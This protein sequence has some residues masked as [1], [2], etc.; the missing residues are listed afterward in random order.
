MLSRNCGCCINGSNY[1]EKTPMCPHCREKMAEL[2]KIATSVASK[3]FEKPKQQ[4]QQQQQQQLDG[5][6]HVTLRPYH[7]HL[8]GEISGHRNGYLQYLI[9]VTGVDDVW[10][11]PSLK[12]YLFLGDSEKQLKACKMLCGRINCIVQRK[13]YY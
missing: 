7:L 11:N 9:W 12:G 6:Y 4:Q 3:V 5:K 13:S 2:K 1:Q 10:F 8:V